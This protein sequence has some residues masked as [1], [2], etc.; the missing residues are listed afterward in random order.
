MG[1]GGEFFHPRVLLKTRLPAHGLEERAGMGKPWRVPRP[2]TH[3]TPG[4]SL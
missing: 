1:G 4:V 2:E 3:K